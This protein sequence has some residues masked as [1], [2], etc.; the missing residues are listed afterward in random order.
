MTNEPSTLPSVQHRYEGLPELSPEQL[1]FRREG[2]FLLLSG[3]F[4]GTLAMLNILGI[5]RFIKLAEIDLAPAEPGTTVFAVAVGVL[6][7]PLTFLCT[8]FICELYGKARANLVVLVGLALNAWVMFIIWVGGML[9][10]FEA[11]DP[12]TG[13]LARDAAGNLPLFFEMRRF[14]FGAVAASMAAYL[15]AQ[16]VDV[17]VFHYWKSLTKGKHQI[18]RAHV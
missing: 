12:A 14:A 11:R 8:D 3:L 17:Y 18:G 16:F 7:Y 6:P 13:E 2:V 5:T 15:A 4:L 1:Y 9:P 10:G